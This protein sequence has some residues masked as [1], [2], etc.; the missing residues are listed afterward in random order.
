MSA[1]TVTLD[2]DG[3]TVVADLPVHIGDV[4]SIAAPLIVALFGGPVSVGAALHQHAL[5]NP[6]APP[7]EV[8]GQLDLLEGA[9]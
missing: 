1:W 7:A 4:A 6:P 5:D 9:A 3:R 2:H 8:P